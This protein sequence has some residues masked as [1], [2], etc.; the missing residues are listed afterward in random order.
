MI[1]D[2]ES[3]R[4]DVK[5][6]RSSK[7]SVWPNMKELKP[8]HCDGGNG[9]GKTINETYHNVYNLIRCKQLMLKIK[10]MDINHLNNLNND[11]PKI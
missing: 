6:Q 2:I 7:N 8:K 5:R 4:V 3:S 1:D 10:K 11:W 9:M